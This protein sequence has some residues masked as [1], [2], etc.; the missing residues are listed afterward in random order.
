MN[1]DYVQNKW[2][3]HEINMNYQIGQNTDL[4]SKFELINVQL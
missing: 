4:F 1:D 2:K 3:H